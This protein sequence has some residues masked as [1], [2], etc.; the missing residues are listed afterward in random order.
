MRIYIGNK[1]E[2]WEAFRDAFPKEWEVDYETISKEDS[3]LFI[4]IKHGLTM[5][6]SFADIKFYTRNGQGDYWA[7]VDILTKKI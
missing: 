5:C 4:K 6:G 7:E 3:H 2:L 1:W